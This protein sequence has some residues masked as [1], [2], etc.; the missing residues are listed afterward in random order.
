MA[1]VFMD[2]IIKEIS[3]KSEALG[4]RAVVQDIAK[5]KFD[6]AVEGMKED[7]EDSAITQEIDAGV[8]APNMSGTLR[9]APGNLFSFIG[10]PAGDGKEYTDP[11][12]EILDPSNANG[13]KLQYVGKDF[14]GQRIRF[15]F[16]AQAPKE[17]AVWAVTLYPPDWGVGNMSWAEDIEGVIPGLKRFM[18]EKGWGRSL[19]GLQAK[20]DIKDRSSDYVAPT[21]GY[22]KAIF[23][24]FLARL[25]RK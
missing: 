20:G 24:R 12:R 5:E 9:G 10:F 4:L 23:A 7:F 1:Y 16:K 15:T 3:D 2:K 8:D 17:K 13:P 11:I 18:E 21:N 14:R 6:A 25:D 19:G 22:I